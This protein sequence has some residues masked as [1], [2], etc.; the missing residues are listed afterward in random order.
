MIN[1]ILLRD[2]VMQSFNCDLWDIGAVLKGGFEMA[3]IRY[4]EPNSVLS[5]LQVT[6]DV[7]LSASAQQSNWKFQ[8]VVKRCERLTSGVFLSTMLLYVRKWAFNKKANREGER[9]TFHNPVE[10]VVFM[11]FANVEFKPIPNWDG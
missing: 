9:Y 4:N 6:G 8:A 5:A 3:N 10:R 2:M 11:I 1:I 7:T